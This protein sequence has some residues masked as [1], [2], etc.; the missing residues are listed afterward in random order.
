M[1][2]AIVAGWLLAIEIAPGRR[3]AG[4]REVRLRGLRSGSPRRRTSWPQVS[5]T[6]F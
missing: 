4:R 1:Q 6:R 2:S 5:Q 3:L